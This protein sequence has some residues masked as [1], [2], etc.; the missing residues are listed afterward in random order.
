MRLLVPGGK[1]QDSRFK[2]RR[3][4]LESCLCQGF[5]LIELVIVMV[6][7]GILGG[8][9]AVFIQHP[10]QA[11]LAATRRAA[12][13]DAADTAL[14]RIVRDVHS[15]LPNSLRVVS[16]SGTVGACSGAEACYLEYL[17]IQGGGRYRAEQT[18]TGTGDVLDFTLADTSFD[19]LGP[20]V[21][22][23]AGQS[24]V[25]YNLGLAGADVWAGQNSSLVDVPHSTACTGSGS[26][27][28]LA[29]GGF[30]FPF[31]SPNKRFFLVAAPVTYACNP[32]AG[33]LRR[34]TGYPL[35]PAQPSTSF[36]G[37]ISNLLADHVLSCTFT[38]APGVTQNL[39]Q[40]TV[41]LQLGQDGETVTL[42]RE[43]AVN[44]DP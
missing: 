42:Y 30:R 36:P 9:V 29:I 25:V 17:P 8:I 5:T 10:L 41:R 24:V 18:G 22:A 38:Y 26:A 27:C 21:T 19:V 14:A 40:L 43:A 32:A 44:N 15:A 6:V 28:T 31:D 34:V 12:L 4:P 11:Y 1:A 16:A 13:V 20:A 2:E 33:E 39:G 37:A 7:V 23:V 3:L 35:Q